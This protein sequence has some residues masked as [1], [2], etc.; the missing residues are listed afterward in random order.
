MHRYLEY[1]ALFIQEVKVI[2][3]VNI[4]PSMSINQIK[5]RY[6]NGIVFDG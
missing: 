5:I 1:A 4:S 2:E 3:L 6:L